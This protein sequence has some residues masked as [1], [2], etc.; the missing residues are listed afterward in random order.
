MATLLLRHFSQC[1]Y[2][3]ASTLNCR[4]IGVHKKFSLFAWRV[5]ISM[6]FSFMCVR[7]VCLLYGIPVVCCC[8]LGIFVEMVSC[9]CCCMLCLHVWVEVSQSLDNPGRRPKVVLIGLLVFF[10]PPCYLSPF[11]LMFVLYIHVLHAFLIVWLLHFFYPRPNCRT[12]LLTQTIFDLLTRLKTQWCY[13][14]FWMTLSY[15][16]EML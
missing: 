1:L 15:C 12:K 6:T 2:F 10:F 8:A 16:M 9:C 5:S 13:Y 7:N 11:V 3:V 14:T 4:E